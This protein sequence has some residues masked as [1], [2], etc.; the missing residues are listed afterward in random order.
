VIVP[1]AIS[2][3]L[4]LLALGSFWWFPTLAVLLGL[5]AVIIGVLGRRRRAA[6]V[7]GDAPLTSAQ[8]LF[9]A[10]IT[11]GTAALVGSIVV[12]VATTG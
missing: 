9:D 6:G 10:G 2:M 12:V 1:G 3:L 5:S 11:M 4:G 8:R 7:R